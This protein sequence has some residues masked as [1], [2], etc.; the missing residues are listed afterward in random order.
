MN[1]FTASCYYKISHF[2]SL[3]MRLTVDYDCLETSY[4]FIYM[5]PLNFIS[6]QGQDS[7]ASL[8]I[9]SLYLL[10]VHFSPHHETRYPAARPTRENP[11][12]SM[13][14]SATIQSALQGY[15]ACGWGRIRGREGD[16][17]SV[18][19]VNGT[20]VNNG[21]GAWALRMATEE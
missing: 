2:V 12:E 18:L 10:Y 1:P 13:N 21:K 4:L 5:I 11:S 14:H 15:V 3:H 19:G 16:H 6:I 20:Q 9:R 7:R 8:S 17:E